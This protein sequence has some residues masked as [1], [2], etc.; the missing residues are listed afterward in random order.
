LEGAGCS[1]SRS[2]TVTKERQGA[3]LIGNRLSISLDF[4]KGQEPIN[5]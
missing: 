5:S 1:Q 2:G 4:P 3:K